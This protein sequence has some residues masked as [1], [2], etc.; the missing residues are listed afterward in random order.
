MGSLATDTEI[1][2]CEKQLSEMLNAHSIVEQERL[3]IQRQILEL[4]LKK[5][6]L[7]IVLDKSKNSIKQKEIEIKLLTKRFW[8]EKNGGI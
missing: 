8:S 1:T 3:N 4:Q 2:N 6:D 7:E 5:K